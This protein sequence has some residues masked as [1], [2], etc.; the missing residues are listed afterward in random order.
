MFSK[1]EKRKEKKKFM[2]LFEAVTQY[3]GNNIVDAY[4]LQRIKD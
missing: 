3:V 1:L 4:P 2:G